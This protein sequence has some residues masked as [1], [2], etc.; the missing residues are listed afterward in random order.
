M[1]PTYRAPIIQ[2]Y[3]ANLQTQLGA[4]WMLE[5]GYQG[6]R[7]TKLLESVSFDQALSASAADPIRGQTTNTL[8]NIALRLPIEGF[9]PSSAKLI[10]SSGASWYNA[11]DVSVT[12]RFSHGLQF[13]ASYTWAS[14]L[15]TNPGFATNAFGGGPVLGN[16]DDPSASYG[17]D[18][19][20]RPQRLIISYIYNVPG[21]ANHTSLRGR[22]LDGWSIAGVTTFQDGHPLTLT[23]TNE[24]N[25]FGVV[26]NPFYGDGDRVQIAS[27]CTYG[28]LA[29]RGSVTSRLDNY[30]N[31]A[32]IG[33]P[34][35]IGSDG[36]ATAFGNS[37]TGIIRGPDENDFDIA[38]SKKTPWGSTEAR[39]VEFRAEFFN[40]F[41]TPNFADPVTSAGT[42]SPN[43]SGVPTLTLNPTFGVIQGTSVNPRIIQLA[44][45]LY[46]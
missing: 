20:I 35:V 28:D 3:S 5:V 31:T 38:I 16:Q 13:L 39:N 45:K 46:F 1:S 29:T 19:F 40:A 14:D 44:L 23:D 25:A 10:E 41:N 11:L 33:V 9:S 21:P 26:T 18:G 22:L 36:L 30:F 24:T 43:S 32:C 42:I 8:A 17:P 2:Q 15:E 12:K 7:G 37:G 6:T 4:N 34:P 27:G